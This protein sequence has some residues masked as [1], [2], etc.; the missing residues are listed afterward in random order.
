MLN[1]I[2]K[3]LKKKNNYYGK[4]IKFSLLNCYQ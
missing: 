2:A 3:I 1:Y 4:Y